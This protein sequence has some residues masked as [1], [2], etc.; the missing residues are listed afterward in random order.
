MEILN[1][2]FEYV[3]ACVIQFVNWVLL[4]IPG[5]TGNKGRSGNTFNI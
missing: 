2:S 3:F 1:L 5:E 4:S